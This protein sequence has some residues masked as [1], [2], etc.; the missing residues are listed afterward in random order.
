MLDGSLGRNILYFARQHKKFSRRAG[1]NFARSDEANLAFKCAHHQYSADSRNISR[2]FAAAVPVRCCHSMDAC[3][4]A[5]HGSKNGHSL[6]PVGV[7]RLQFFQH[8]TGQ[9]KL[10]TGPFSAQSFCRIWGRIFQK[11]ARNFVRGCCDCFGLYADAERN[12]KSQQS[13]APDKRR[14]LNSRT[15]HG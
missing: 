8:K 15:Y 3:S 6:L 7:L 5:G 13:R 2:S 12:I 9:S 14:H 11:F 10:G 1:T 4:A